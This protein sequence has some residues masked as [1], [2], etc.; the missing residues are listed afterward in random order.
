MCKNKKIQYKIIILAFP[1]SSLLVKEFNNSVD[2][3]YLIAFE[4][5][6]CNKNEGEIMKEYNQKQIQFIIDFLIEANAN[7]YIGYIE[8]IFDSCKKKFIENITDI[9]D[10]IKS[11]NCLIYKGKNIINS[12]IEF[13]NYNIDSKIFLYESFLKLK[14]NKYDFPQVNTSEIY[15]LIKYLK[16]EKIQIFYCNESNKR[17]Y[18]DIS[19]E[20]MKFYYRHKTFCEYFDINMNKPHDRALLK[21]II[22]KLKTIKNEN[23]EESENEN[24]DDNTKS[25]V[26][27]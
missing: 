14:N 8:T 18:L 1:K 2:Y 3:Q 12:K 24:E 21:S 26:F 22:R 10:G 6:N 5:F 23:N 7:N 25:L 13:I 17:M 19:Y 20:V 27:L 9:N 15:D 16:N 11:G 4:H